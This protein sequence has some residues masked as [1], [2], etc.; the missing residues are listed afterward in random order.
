VTDDSGFSQWVNQVRQ[1]N[2]SLDLGTYDQLAQ[3]SHDGSVRHYS[4]AQAGLFNQ[5]VAKY[6]APIY[7]KPGEKS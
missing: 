5:I 1:E 4:S 2:N 3:P 6:E 7:F